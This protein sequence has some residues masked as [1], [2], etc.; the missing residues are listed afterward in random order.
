MAFVLGEHDIE[1]IKNLLIE[2]GD[3][4]ISTQKKGVLYT[5]KSDSTIVTQTD[6]E[7]QEF[8][9]KRIRQRLPEIA[10]VHEEKQEENPQII[11]ERTTLAIIDPLDGTAVYTMGLPTW[12]ISIGFYTDFQP[13]Y[14]FVYSPVS[15]LFYHNDDSAAYC[16]GFPIAVESTMQI[17]S[18][19][20]IFVTAE[21]FRSYYIRFPG[22][23]RNLGSTALHGCMVADN[24][25]TRTLAYIGRSY[26]W[27]WGGVIPILLKAGGSLR[28]LSG[29]HVDIREIVA[30]GFLLPEYCI[31]YSSYNHE[32]IKSYL[33]ELQ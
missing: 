18:E 1:Y 21:I 32:L 33:F 11:G 23:V 7:I 5:R 3:I 13:Q 16:N 27:D 10:F 28:Y 17:D 29:K 9:V 20:N 22:K 8:L 19:T 31:A 4:G 25:R 15:K 30:N 26:L 2:A 24:A 14:G 6:I 12:C